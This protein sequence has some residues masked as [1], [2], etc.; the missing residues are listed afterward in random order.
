MKDY[1][2]YV[3]NVSFEQIPIKNLVS[4][5]DYQRNLSMRHVKRAVEN[6]NLYQINPVKVSRRNGINYVFNGQH[7]IEII[8]LVSG[9]R[10]TPVW[11]MVYDDLYYEQEADI[12]ANQMKYVKALTPYE[13]FFANIEAG[14]DKQLIIKDLVESFGLHIAPTKQV[15]A[16]CAVSTIES[17]YDKYGLQNLT[18]VLRLTI[19][20][21]EGDVN[22]F[23]A[24]MLSAIARLIFV[25]D[26][27]IVDNVFKEKLGERSIKEITRSAHERS[28]GSLGF[29]EAIL[30]FYN[31]KMKNPLDILKLHIGKGHKM[32]G[33]YSDDDSDY[34][35]EYE[36]INGTD[37]IIASA[38]VDGEK[39]L[40]LPYN[41]VLE[42]TA[43]ESALSS[44]F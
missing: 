36:Y 24:N 34:D 31:K 26:T 13:I 15:G 14:N 17:I 23:S 12:F 7:T 30:C 25:Y 8:A 5:Q 4:S 32:I 21:W 16:I 33:S 20:T 42:D 11:C 1:S 43:K 10:D 39:Q 3:P 29:A 38:G 27:E 37:E 35:D 6:F 19:G 41:D 28:S 44:G 2:M 22:S 40:S 9:S 18:R